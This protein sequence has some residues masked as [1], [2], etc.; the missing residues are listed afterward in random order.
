MRAYLFDIDGTLAN[1]DHRKHHIEGE[2]KDW[3][4]FYATCHL[5]APIHHIVDLAR[6]LDFQEGVVFVTG[7]GEEQ[8]GATLTWLRVIG[9]W[10]APVL[11]M[12]PAKDYRA[13]DIVKGE[14]LDR[15]IADGYEPIMAFDDRN[16]VVKMWRARGIPC[17]QVAEGDF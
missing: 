5:D 15:I 11:Y 6:L 17:A 8:R 3:D 9:G 2:K 14:L 10:Y 16:S 7:R 12:R 13:D 4:A 1:C